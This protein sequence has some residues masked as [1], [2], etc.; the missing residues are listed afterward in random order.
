MLGKDVL[1]NFLTV[2][3]GSHKGTEIDDTTLG[4]VF[5]RGMEN[6]AAEKLSWGEDI[7]EL[8]IEQQMQADLNEDW[9]VSGRAD[10]RYLHLPSDVY[11]IHDYKLIKHYAAS[12]VVARPD[13]PYRWQLGVLRWLANLTEPAARDKAVHCFIDIFAKDAKRLNG[14]L[15]YTQIQVPTGQILTNDIQS[16]LESSTRAIQNYIEC[17]DIPPQCEDLWWRT[18]G[19]TKV[20]TKCAL[21]CSHGKAGVCPY[22]KPPRI[23]KRL[24]DW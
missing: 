12:Q 22:Y 4:S 14:E 19:K 5:H 6:I 15:T 3:Y 7:A 13:H 23:E 11:C 2:V 17:G 10:L 20:P 24:S 21:Y 16:K 9:I 18:V 1:Q 8:S